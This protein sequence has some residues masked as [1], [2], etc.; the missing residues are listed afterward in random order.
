MG[1]VEN[2][3]AP[4]KHR[5]G[6]A[7]RKA[8]RLMFERYGHTCWLCGHDGA[9]QADHLGPLAF[10]PEQPID[11]D[12]MRPAHGGAQQEYD[13]PCPTCGRRCN[14]ERGSNIN[15]TMFQPALTW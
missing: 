7:F 14:Q 13:N 8:K 3:P 12:A 1:G 15:F 5:G 11:A 2:M 6:Y 4:A 9:L 10:D